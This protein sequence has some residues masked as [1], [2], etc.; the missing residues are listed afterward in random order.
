MPSDFDPNAPKQ[1]IKLRINGELLDKAV[2]LNIDLSRALEKAI[3]EAVAQHQCERRFE[4]N[5]DLLVAAIGLLRDETRAKQWLTTPNLALAGQCP[6]DAGR[7]DV[8][9]LIGRLEHG[10]CA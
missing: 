2:E 7:K 3:A 8:L 10:F 9:D 5:P 6:I 4:E 1:M